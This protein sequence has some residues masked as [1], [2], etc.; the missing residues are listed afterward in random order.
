M[1][2]CLTTLG[3]FVL[4]VLICGCTTAT[5]R[6]A[7]YKTVLPRSTEIQKIVDDLIGAKTQDIVS[8]LGEPTEKTKWGDEEGRILFVYKV[9]EKSKLSV[10]V[11]S[12]RV[13]KAL[14]IISSN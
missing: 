3:L 2:K 13:V 5:Y 4:M 7:R 10:Y 6:D 12:G 11:A 9:D 14:L 8:T 1:K